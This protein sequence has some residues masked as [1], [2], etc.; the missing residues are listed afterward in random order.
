MTKKPQRKL[1]I[2]REAV[3]QL[4]GVD[5]RQVRGGDSE[6]TCVTWKPNAQQPT[7]GCPPG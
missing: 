6:A 2:R 1:A 5:L 7:V 4:D 3:R